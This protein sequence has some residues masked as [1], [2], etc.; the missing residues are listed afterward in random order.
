MRLQ[1][2]DFKSKTPVKRRYDF[3]ALAK[4][5]LADSAGYV[6]SFLSSNI[7]G[8]I[9]FSSKR[10][11]IL[12]FSFLLLLALAWLQTNK[13]GNSNPKIE[14]L[15]HS[16]TLPETIAAQIPTIL[17][18]STA[19]KSPSWRSIK[20]IPGD[21]LGSIFAAVGLSPS[22][23]HKVVNLNKQTRM[24]RS[25]R[26]DQSIQILQDSSQ[27]LLSLK[28]APDITTTLR[29]DQHD[30]KNLSSEII[31]H[32]LDAIPVFRS[33]IIRSSLFEA[34]A[35]SDIPDNLIMELANVFAWDIDF[36]LDIRKG[37]SFRIVY[38][39]LYKE[40]IKIKEG[41]I[42]A[43]EFINNKKLYQAVYYTDPDGKSGYFTPDGKSV[44]KAF[45]RS[46]VKFSRISSRFSL[47]RWHPVLSRWRSHKG[48]DYAAARGTPIRA[49]GDG[50]LSFVG[51]KG[52]YGKAMILS[53]GGRYTTLYG[54]LS[55]FKKGMR[56]GRRIKQGQIIGFVGSTGLAT[57]PHLHYEFRVHGVHRNPLTVKLPAAQPVNSKFRADFDKNTIN[58]ISLLHLM[59]N[60]IASN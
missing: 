36:A 26:P 29:I 6:S 48:V 31:H 59:D 44:R 58:Y 2:L 53:H 55:S 5:N 12:S 15:H 50:K 1:E 7:L 22:M 28:Y 27:K 39:E 40:G 8:S 52:G 10:T 51:K 35:E 23:T 54:H 46:P 57:G 11:L 30:D 21:T 18:A 20:I 47:K 9:R 3:S 16:L 45:L 14:R 32:Q 17:E 43:A 37:D 25:I 19:I 56:K 13:S 24:L 38:N 49:A 33:G 60:R 42:L 4:R 41:Q 34:A